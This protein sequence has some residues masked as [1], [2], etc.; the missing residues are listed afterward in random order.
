MCVI[1]TANL[2]LL[3]V[4]CYLQVKYVSSTENCSPCH[5]KLTRSNLNELT[6]SLGAL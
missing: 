4:I 5:L 2:L 6:V 1:L 3:K